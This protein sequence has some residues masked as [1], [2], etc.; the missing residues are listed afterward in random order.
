MQR[1]LPWPAAATYLAS[2]ASLAGACIRLQAVLDHRRK[3]L[4][5]SLYTSD[6]WFGTTLASSCR[7]RRAILAAAF[8]ALNWPFGRCA[9]RHAGLLRS[10]SGAGTWRDAAASRGGRGQ[11][12][13]HRAPRAEAG[14]EVKVRRGR[15]GGRGGN[16]VWGG[17][18]R[19]GAD[20]EG[21]TRRRTRSQHRLIGGRVGGGCSDVDRMA[22][23]RKGIQVG[24]PDELL[25]ERRIDSERRPLG[26][27]GNDEAVAAV[28][29]N[30]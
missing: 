25:N 23:V 1:K 12:R 30:R 11:R 10:G 14:P 21:E 26:G 19:S 22:G 15:A 20:V 27:V 18:E 9:A 16:R 7:L 3:V 28:W 8:P 5:R 13:A 2:V 24:R 4:C 17:Q 29:L 6:L